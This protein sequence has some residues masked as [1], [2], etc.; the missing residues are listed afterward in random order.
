MD[1][2]HR[3]HSQQIYSLS[4][5]T[6]R[7]PLH[8]G[9]L[10]EK[11]VAMCVGIEPTSSDLESEILPLNYHTSSIK[12]GREKGIRTLGCFHIDGFQ[13]RCF[14]PLSHLSIIQLKSLTLILISK[15]PSYYWRN[16]DERSLSVASMFFTQL[17]RLS[18][19]VS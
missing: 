16:I 8:I 10:C 4:P 13:D 12:N 11:E 5:L 17:T 18:V 2:N 6:T 19:F 7:A 1:S 9:V 15:T 14:Q 3:R